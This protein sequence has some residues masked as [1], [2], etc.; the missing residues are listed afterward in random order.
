MWR[1]KKK[2]VDFVERGEAL[3]AS[4]Q[5]SPETLAKRR[6]FGVTREEY[7]RNP[8]MQ[9]AAQAEYERMMADELG[10]DLEGRSFDEA[11]E[12]AR[13]ARAEVLRAEWRARRAEETRR[14]R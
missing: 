1:R 5:A 10:L 14:S 13:R 7:D 9:R 12:E 8:A 3:L 6:E 2:P 4:L 11:F